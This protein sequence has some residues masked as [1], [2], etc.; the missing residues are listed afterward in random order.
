MF[1]QNSRKFQQQN[2]IL[3]AM[4]A[5]IICIL[6]RC[7]IL[8]IHTCLNDNIPAILCLTVGFILHWK[9]V[10][11]AF[12]WKT[13]ETH[14]YGLMNE[15]GIEKMWENANYSKRKKKKYNHGQSSME[16]KRVK[17]PPFLNCCKHSRFQGWKTF[18][19]LNCEIYVAKNIKVNKLSDLDQHCL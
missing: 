9:Q 12:G 2:E 14:S 3:T 11:Y 6:H 18:F 10:C 1:E 15:K 17:M 19:M 13:K 7:A 5:S 8:T 4:K 16:S